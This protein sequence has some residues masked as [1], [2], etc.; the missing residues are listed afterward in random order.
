MQRISGEQSAGEVTR[1]MFS[2]SYFAI[3]HEYTVKIGG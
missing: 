2:L 3:L 1:E